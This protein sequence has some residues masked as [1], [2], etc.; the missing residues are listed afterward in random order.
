MKLKFHHPEPKEGDLVGPQYWRSLDELA[1]KPEFKEWVEREFPQGAS[2]LEGVNRRKFLRIMS[3]SFAAAGAGLAGCRRPEQKILPYSRQ[4]GDN[5]PEAAIPGI[6]VHYS[7]AFPDAIDSLPLIVET[8]QNRP[9]HIEGNPDYAPYGGSTSGFIQASVLDLY[10]PDRMRSASEGQ[11]ARSVAR[12]VVTDR[13]TSIHSKFAS[14]RGRG[15]AVLAAPSSSPT[16]ARV[17]DALL[18]KLPRAV[19]AEYEP[20][21]RDTSQKAASSVF[22]KSVRPVLHLSKADRIL[23]ID[24]DFLSKEPGANGLARGYAAGRKVKNRE[25]AGKMNRLYAVESTYTVSGAMADHRLRLSTS[26][27]A[28]FTLKLAATV[29]ELLHL[30]SGL[31][32][33]LGSKVSTEGI[34]TEWVKECAKDLVSK[35]GH[36]VVLAGSHLPVEVHALVVL[37]N[38]LLGANGKTVEYVSAP[39]FQARSIADLAAQ[40]EQG[41]V[42]TLIILGGNPAYNA[43]AGL[44]FTGLLKKVPEV[45]RYGYHFDETSVEAG[46]NVAAAHYLESWSDARA[47]D[48]TYFP[49]QPMILP[50]FDCWQENEFLATLAALPVKDPYALVSETFTG[51][52]GGGA[53]DFSRLLSK[54]IQPD[55]AFAAAKVS[56]SVSKAKD[57][58]STAKFTSTPVDQENLEVRLV[59]DDSVGD[60]T[61]T[62]NGWMQEC[63]DPMT[64][65]AWDNAILVSPKLAKEVL[66]F[67]PP[68]GR[69]LIQG[70]AKKSEI[71]VGGREIAP[72]AKLTVGET[73]VTG[74][75][76]VQPGLADW[77]VVVPLGYGRRNVGRVGKDVGFD[78]YPL[79]GNSAFYSTGAKIALTGRTM[80]LANTQEHWSM[81]GRAI[82]REANASTHEADPKWVEKMGMESHSPAVYGKDKNMSLREKSLATPRGGS[83]YE[84]PDFGTPPSNVDAWDSE[85][86]KA[87]FIPEQQWGMTIDLNTCTGCNACI[88]ACQSENNI[89]IVGKEQVMRGRE[90]HWIRLDRYFSSGDIE[91]NR[92]ELP[93]DPQASLMPVACMQCEMAPC[94]QVCPV[95]ATVHDSQGL[96]TMAYNRCVGTRYCANNCPYK[97][98]RFN[99]FDYNKR[100]ADEFY[101]GPLGTNRYKTEEGNLKAMQ[102][103]P[104]VSVRMRGVME[105]CTYCVQRIQE[106]KIAQ[107]VKAKDSNNIHV[108]EGIIRMACQTACPSDAIVFGDISDPESAVSISK[109]NDRNYSLLGYLNTRPRTT[110]L[111][112]LRNPN[113]KMP[114]YH[115]LALSRMEYEKSQ[116]HGSDHGGEHGEGHGGG[117]EEGHG[118]HEEHEDHGH[119]SHG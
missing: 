5:V 27:M 34:D 18:S 99:F 86:A 58:F 26:E 63:P 10:D 29:L 91:E 98:R 93:S 119:E 35:K 81:E 61:Y 2:E 4:S 48:G 57:Y 106:A 21:A 92:D 65:L 37:I 113:K 100:E 44:N 97:V 101:F 87:K 9:T 56:F 96:N 46:F 115:E 22:G 94:E 32:S 110:Y 70:I 28:A 55:S 59:K 75:I 25:D 16:R 6:P 24:A 77:T 89:P 95:N 53:K 78:A 15:L 68:S 52:F 66:G 79:S 118:G 102:S 40:I 104:D 51:L 12:S 84:T 7:T 62:N 73:S 108:P 13:L 3:A 90:M 39:E 43:P 69:F 38:E 47:F 112:R 33:T 19:W 17:R 20:I 36:S 31:A 67:D 109:E 1:D 72:V 116:G 60:G 117:H 105:K 80:R 82:V 85:E 54:G 111:A 11:P 14:A 88:V 64:K 114:D 74:P 71:M 49:V 45:V 23:A 83:L 103:N 41:S 30:D 107:K 50:L 76:H 42:E 8:H